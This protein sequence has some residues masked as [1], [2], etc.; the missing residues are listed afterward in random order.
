MRS[1]CVS[2]T[3]D[4]RRILREGLGDLGGGGGLRCESPCKSESAATRRAS[5]D[6]R[7]KQQ[8]HQKVK[9]LGRGSF[10]SVVLGEWQ[11]QKG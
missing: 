10:G 4:R 5:K 9:L 8:Q 11:G 6:S 3:P 7:R 2:R 1:L